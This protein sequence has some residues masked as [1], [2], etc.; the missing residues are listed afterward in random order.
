MIR[1]YNQSDAIDFIHLYI[2]SNS[3]GQDFY[4]P[5][6]WKADS[7]TVVNE[8]LPLSKT[9]LYEKESKIIGAISL[10]DDEITG[11]IVSPNHW[12]QGIGRIL[13][14]HVKKC[15]EQL[16]LKVFKKNVRALRFY[17]EN[18]FKII[19]EGVCELTGLEEYEMSWS[20]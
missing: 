14:N 3:K 6:F 17:Q 11:L 20:V 1:E 8:Y 13:M 2:E 4:D 12:R 9:W 5:E 16:C 7:Q 15:K 18:G 10:K 19:K